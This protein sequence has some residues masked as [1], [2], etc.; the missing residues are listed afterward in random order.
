VL[1]WKFLAHLG[2]SKM[3]GISDIK[4]VG[5][6]ERRPPVIRKEPYIDVIFKLSHQAPLDWCQDFNGLM[7]KHP[8]RPK[9]K[10]KEGLFIEG[11]VKT[12]DDIALFLEV[13]KEKVDICSQEYIKRIEQVVRKANEVNASVAKESGEQ[14]RLNRII[15]NLNF[16]H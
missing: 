1:A 8:S 14:G 3:E 7:S 13:L 11:W 15:A 5:I 9:I 4:I 16:D 12:P 2:V 10:E 6:D